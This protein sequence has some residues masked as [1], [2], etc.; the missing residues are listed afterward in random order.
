ML[1][2]EDTQSSRLPHIHEHTRCLCA[3]R[4]ATLSTHL[5]KQ[6]TTTYVY[7]HRQRQRDPS[8]HDGAVGRGGREGWAQPWAGGRTHSIPQQVDQEG[9][10]QEDS[11][12]Q[13]GVRVRSSS[14][15][16]SQ[17]LLGEQEGV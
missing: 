10:E 12:L 13:G 4:F 1:E 5:A 16:R 7:S 2:S 6:L 17:L 15:G 9:P 3:F 14:H 11:Q 8:D